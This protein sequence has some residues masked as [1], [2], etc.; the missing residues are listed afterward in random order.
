VAGGLGTGAKIGIGVGIGF[1]AVAVVLAAWFIWAY[2]K[3]RQ[4]SAH[5]IQSSDTFGGGASDFGMAD[6]PRHQYAQDNMQQGGAAELAPVAW[7]PPAGYEA[8]AYTAVEDKNGTKVS[9]PL[10]AE[11]GSDSETQQQPVELPATE[12]YLGYSDQSPGHSP[13]LGHDR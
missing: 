13:H 12:R 2:Q 11:L 4:R 9:V 5:S 10:L 6:A 7:K 8:P 1:G 3:R